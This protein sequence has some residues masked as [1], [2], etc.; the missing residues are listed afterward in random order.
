LPYTF[1]FIFSG[2]IISDVG[3]VVIA[4]RVTTD[5]W[6]MQ[7]LGTTGTLVSICQNE[8]FTFSFL[9]NTYLYLVQVVTCA[10]SI[11]ATWYIQ[12]HWEIDVKKIV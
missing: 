2:F 3:V 12:R 8:Q 7:G 5:L 10:A 11:V 4:H 6:R 9:Q 1:I